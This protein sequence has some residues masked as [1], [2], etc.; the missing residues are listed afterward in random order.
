MSLS[1]TTALLCSLS[2]T[3]SVSAL[4]AGAANSS[5]FRVIAVTLYREL[6]TPDVREDHKLML[7]VIRNRAA[8]RNMTLSAV[9]LERWQ[10]S[11]WNRFWLD[12]KSTVTAKRLDTEFKKV[13]ESFTM[14]LSEAV[15][16]QSTSVTQSSGINH[17][18]SPASMRPKFSEP[19]WARGKTPVF[20]TK[21]FRYYAL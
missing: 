14:A 17:F 7:A 6:Q 21:R 18:Y 10:F 1:T 19:G 8:A 5:S 4:V 12:S 16:N 3:T 2:A 9:C 11:Y 15:F 13:P 20:V